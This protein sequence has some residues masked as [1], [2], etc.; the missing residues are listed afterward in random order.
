MLAA[1]TNSGGS[2]ERK[3]PSTEYVAAWF[4]NGHGLVPSYSQIPE[5]GDIAGS[6]ISLL[7]T[8]P[9]DPLRTFVPEGSFVSSGEREGT[10]S[11]QVELSDGFWAQPAGEA[12]A[13]AAQI[14]NTLATL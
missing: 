12:Y 2:N 8:A 7:G 14:V 11:I 5:G 4:V 13:G 1:C 6:L 3:E 10:E 9:G